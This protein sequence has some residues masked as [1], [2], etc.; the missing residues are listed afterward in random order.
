MVHMPFRWFCHEVAQM[1]VLAYGELMHLVSF[2]SL[3][4][5]GNFRDLLLALL[6][7]IPLLKRGLF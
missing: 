7:V 3:Y 5:A 6:H 4:K 2:F 1:L